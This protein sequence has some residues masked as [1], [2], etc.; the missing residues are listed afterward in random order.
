MGDGGWGKGD[1]DGWGMGDDMYA[2]TYIIGVEWS[3]SLKL[4]GMTLS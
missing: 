2:P 3:I 1:D 4:C